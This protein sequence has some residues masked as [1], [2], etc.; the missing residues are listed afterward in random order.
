M[1]WWEYHTT[2]KLS[3]NKSQ[4]TIFKKSR[5][6]FC[7]LLFGLK[8]LSHFIKCA[9]LLP[10]W[11][12][13]QVENNPLYWPSSLLLWPE[14]VWI[15][16]PLL[17]SRKRSAFFFFFFDVAH[18]QH[19]LPTIGST[20]EANLT[21]KF[22]NRCWEK[23]RLYQL[24]KYDRFYNTE[25]ALNLI[26]SLNKLIYKGKKV[27]HPSPHTHLR[28]HVKL[29]ALADECKWK[30]NEL[31]M[32]ILTKNWMQSGVKGT[33]LWRKAQLSADSNI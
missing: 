21:L 33:F 19:M 26:Q 9:Q 8:K 27:N 5:D 31:L 28:F 6:Q 30:T 1:L 29:P 17:Y 24:W 13:M 32:K 18:K 14:Q 11:E 4:V 15:P 7:R 20:L 25:N 12:K 23:K 16:K 2:L 22:W 10:V 3:W